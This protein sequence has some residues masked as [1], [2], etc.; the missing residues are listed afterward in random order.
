MI[1]VTINYFGN[2]IAE[3]EVKGHSYY[4][5]KGNDIVCAGVSSIIIGGLNAIDALVTDNN[6]DYDVRDGYV[7][8]SSLNNI[9]V[10][11]ILKILIIQLKTVEDSY[12]KY[13]KI[14]ESYQ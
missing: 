1:K 5:P 12:S 6:I 2:D 4:A 9:E 7:K 3:L 13:I 11:K 10:Q 14:V 8:M